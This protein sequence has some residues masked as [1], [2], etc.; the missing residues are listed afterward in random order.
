M[1]KTLGGSNDIDIDVEQ[2]TLTGV[3]LWYSHSPHYAN[4]L[5]LTFLIDMW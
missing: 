1:T 3:L 2:M 5:Q 4:L